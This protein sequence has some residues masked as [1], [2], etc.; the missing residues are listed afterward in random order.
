MFSRAS[1]FESLTSFYQHSVKDGY[2]SCDFSRATSG[3]VSPSDLPD[4]PGHSRPRTPT[5]QPQKQQ[6]SKQQQQQPQGAEAAAADSN[7]FPL[8]V[9][10]PE[11]QQPSI[12]RELE[13]ARGENN[14]P[15]PGK[16]G[17]I[18]SQK[19]EREKATAEGK[20]QQL[21]QQPTNR[22]KDE[23]DA[24]RPP[25]LSEDGVKTYQEEGTPGVFSSRTSLSR[26]TFSDEDD[27]EIAKV[28]GSSREKVRVIKGV[29]QSCRSAFWVKCFT[30]ILVISGES[31]CQKQYNYQWCQEV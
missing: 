20:A 25:L 9:R 15:K 31:T 29:T 12:G 26:L 17:M 24:I 11:A 3:R 28:T 18:Q 23:V 13:A 7:S 1:S 16:D 5:G 22:E 21:Q 27:E 19:E 30:F 4:S 6:L 8:E 14:A 10:K 2:S